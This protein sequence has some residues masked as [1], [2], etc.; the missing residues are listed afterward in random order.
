[1]TDQ[2][3]LVSIVV[4]IY[5]CEKYIED[6]I[7][8]LLNQTYDNL[9]IVLVD[10]GSKDQTYQLCSCFIDKRILLLHKENGGASSARNY[11]MRYAQGEY[12]LFADSDD[13]LENDAVR[14]LVELCEAEKADLI[15]F[16][17]ENYTDDETL[18]I[19]KE[20]LSQKR[21]YPVLSGNELIPLLIE[22]KDYHVP[23]FLFFIKRGVFGTGL[24][25]KEGIMMEDELFAF[26]LL[27]MCERVVCL[28]KKLYH[29]RVRPGS[30][31]T[32]Q[33]KEQF[34]YISIE[35]VFQE[36][37]K[38]RE[39]G[40]SDTTLELY[41]A[42]VGMLVVGYWEQLPSEK[43]KELQKQYSTVRR[44]IRTEKG[45]GS[46]ELLIRTY[47]F[48]PWAVYVAPNRMMKKLRKQFC[49]RG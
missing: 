7:R 15:Y 19:K 30:V 27:R 23:P 13:Y 47:G 2:M 33:G 46:R 28:R 32:S 34:R 26:Q 1:M 35:T 6:C 39:N 18:Q 45:F 22:N 49:R 36:L 10:D 20:G 24:S 25:F 12:L 16:E 41:L 29:R 21:D 9:Q 17:A 44:L 43:K 37:L 4:P 5:N 38:M 48:L 42:R 40:R 3:P 31:M 8:S 14:T 11:G